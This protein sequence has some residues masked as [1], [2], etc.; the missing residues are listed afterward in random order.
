METCGIHP[1]SAGGHG[2]DLLRPWPEVADPVC[3]KTPLPSPGSKRRPKKAKKTTNQRNMTRGGHRDYEGGHRSDPLCPPS[4]FDMLSAL[5]GLRWHKHP[6]GL[7]EEQ[8]S[9]V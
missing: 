2:S 9:L 1:G 6:P 4:Y 8:L 5:G 3:Q 7:K